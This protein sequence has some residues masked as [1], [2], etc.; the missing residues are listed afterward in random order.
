[1]GLQHVS[2]R[3]GTRAHSLDRRNPVQEILQK[4][5]IVWV[6]EEFVTSSEEIPGPDRKN[7]AATSE[8]LMGCPDDRPP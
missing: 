7:L 5:S 3:G 4:S 8:V 6:I 2:L 1:M